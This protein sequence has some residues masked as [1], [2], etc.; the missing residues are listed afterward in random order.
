[1][2][3]PWLHRYAVLLAVCTFV[4]SVTGTFVSSSEERPLASVGQGHYT[5]GISVGILTIGLAVWLSRSEKRAWL[6]KLGW[7]AL[8]AVMVESGL[9]FWP[10]PRPT[11]LN[12]SHDL[13]AQLVF[14]TI[15]AIG[16]FTSPAWKRGPELVEEHGRL[17]P[18]AI[19]TV[20][21][22]VMQVALGTAFR[23]GILG[24]TPHLA[25][26]MLVLLLI[27]VAGMLT[28]QNF[29]SHGALCLAARTLMGI[30]FLQCSWDSPYYLWER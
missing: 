8:A 25:G 26:A 3:S 11:A 18:L 9:G 14:S 22:A 10:A 1:M 13:L 28:T 2:E 12:F 7:I 21:L 17:R 29:P 15:V 23:Q 16:V 30:S 19:V 4:L 20:A 5:E 6:R 27:L 24:M